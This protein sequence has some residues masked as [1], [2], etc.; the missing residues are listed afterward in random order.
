MHY[1]IQQ[2]LLLFWRRTFPFILHEETTV[3][4]AKFDSFRWLP[5]SSLLF[6][7][8]VLNWKWIPAEWQLQAEM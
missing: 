7:I 5:P 1:F 4:H 6:E 8:I 2:T 3:L